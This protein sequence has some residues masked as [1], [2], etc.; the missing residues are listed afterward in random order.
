MAPVLPPFEPEPSPL[1]LSVGAEPLPVAVPEGAEEGDEEDTKGLES[2]DI[3]AAVRSNSN[4][5][6]LFGPCC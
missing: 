4:W 3:A 1:L 2:L 5:C 6:M